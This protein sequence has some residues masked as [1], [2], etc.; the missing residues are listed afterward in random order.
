MRTIVTALLFLMTGTS[1]ANSTSQCLN[2]SARVTLNSTNANDLT[3]LV[4]II[5]SMP[6]SGQLIEDDNGIA[7]VEIST[8]KDYADLNDLNSFD[9]AKK[10]TDLLKERTLEWGVQ[11]VDASVCFD[12]YTAA[13]SNAGTIG[14]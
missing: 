13:M 10:V 4:M 9:V 7:Q 3:S 14:H 2:N 8:P 6:L 11:S 12:D 1:F 5:N